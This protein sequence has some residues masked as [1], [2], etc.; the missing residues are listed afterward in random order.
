MTDIID[1]ID[2][3]VDEQLQQEASGYDHNINQDKCP[4][5]SLD[6]HGL[7]ITA[8]IAEMKILGEFDPEYEHQDSPVICLGSD[9]IGPMRGFSTKPIIESVMRKIMSTL[10]TGMDFLFGSSE[11]PELDPGWF[12]EFCETEGVDPDGFTLDDFTRSLAAMFQ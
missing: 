6:W 5:C 12:E 7:P 11:P 4:H 9:F 10:W 1:R 2:S 3:L 8:K